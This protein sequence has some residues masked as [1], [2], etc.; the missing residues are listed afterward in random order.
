MSFVVI[1]VVERDRAFQVLVMLPMVYVEL[2]PI[3]ADLHWFLMRSA[4]R[5]PL[6]FGRGEVAAFVSTRI[7]QIRHTRIF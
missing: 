2:R 6:W 4:K 3:P 7:G 5:N 1:K